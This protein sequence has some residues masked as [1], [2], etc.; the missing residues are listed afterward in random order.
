MDDNGAPYRALFGEIVEELLR[1]G[2]HDLFCTTLN[3]D[4]HLRV[5]NPG[6]RSEEGQ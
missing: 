6:A 4:T 3:H 5:L 2:R 1:Q